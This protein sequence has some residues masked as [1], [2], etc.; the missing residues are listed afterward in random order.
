MWLWKNTDLEARKSDCWDRTF[1]FKLFYKNVTHSTTIDEA[2][3]LKSD[4]VGNFQ[5]LYYRKIVFFC[6]EPKKFIYSVAEM[7]DRI[8]CD[9]YSK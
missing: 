1:H 9:S 8:I 7:F 4:V 5:M 2:L 3:S 6:Y